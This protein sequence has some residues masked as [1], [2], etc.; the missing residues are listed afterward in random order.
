VQ[1]QEMKH[2]LQSL[3][4]DR[5]LVM[6]FGP[7]P[8]SQRMDF[9]GALTS[10]A[11]ASPY[12]VP[13]NCG[14]SAPECG[15]LLSD[16]LKK[17]ATSAE[18]DKALS[19]SFGPQFLEK[20][21]FDK[22]WT[23]EEQRK[24]VTALLVALK[25]GYFFYRQSCLATTSDGSNCDPKDT[26][27]MLGRIACD[28]EDDGASSGCVYA[29]L[30][31]CDGGC[32][33]HGGFFEYARFHGPLALLETREKRGHVMGQ[34]EEFSRAAYA[35]LTSLGYEARYVLDFT[36]HVWVEVKLLP[37]NSSGSGQKT[38][39]VHADPSEGVLDQPLMYE[40]GWGKKLTMIFAMT[41]WDLE[42]VTARYTANY[43]LTVRRRGILEEDMQKVVGEANRRLKFELPVRKWGYGG[44][45]LSRDRSFAEVAL[46]SHFDLAG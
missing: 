4:A 45:R 2:H 28:S 14:Q 42:H 27:A 10:L 41:P 46:W 3:W 12:L 23:A 39:W 13:P 26:S 15:V 25:G 34:C 11:R 43:D 30:R 22:K 8:L 21:R 36:D 5:R 9:V 19:R 20:H 6:G 24:H 40:Q 31:R 38:E 33:Q 35:L 1:I 32:G 29:E 17:S 37:K 7:D 16:G 44:G 18:L